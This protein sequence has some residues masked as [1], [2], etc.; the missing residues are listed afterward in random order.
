[1]LSKEGKPF[2]LIVTRSSERAE[3][4]KNEIRKLCEANLIVVYHPEF[5]SI[6]KQNWDLI[7]YDCAEDED[8]RMS[9]ML[10]LFS[11]NIPLVFVTDSKKFSE[12]FEVRVVRIKDLS[13]VLED[14]I[15][16]RKLKRKLEKKDELLRIAS[17]IAE[18]G[19]WEWNLETDR[20]YLSPECQ[21]ILG[22]ENPF[23]YEKN[24]LKFVISENHEEINRKKLE[25]ISEGKPF[26]LQLLFDSP[27]KGPTWISVFGKAEYDD[28]GNPK[29]VIGVV[30]DVSKQKEAE[31]KLLL[32]EARLKLI[33]DVIPIM[34]IHLDEKMKCDFANQTFCRF[35]NIELENA[36]GKDLSEIVGQERFSR[37]IPGVEKAFGGEISKFEISIDLEYRK[38]FLSVDFIPDRD[39]KGEVKGCFVFLRDNTDSRLAFENLKESEER[40]RSL[41]K[42]T[43]QIVW[44]SPVRKSLDK[45]KV[46]FLFDSISKVG[47][48]EERFHTDDYKKLIEDLRKN[49]QKGSSYEAEYRIFHPEDNSYHTYVLK[50]FPI[51][52]DGKIHEFIGTMTDVTERQKA[53]REIK[54]QAELLN[55]VNQAILTTDPRGKLIY[56][57]KFAEELFGW[58]NENLLGRYIFDLIVPEENKETATKITNRVIKGVPWSGEFEMKKRDGTRFIASFSLWSVQE[59]GRTKLV[60]GLVQDITEKKEAERRLKDS[61]EQLQQAQK[62]ESIGRLAGGIAHDFNNMLTAIKGY[63]ELAL[64]QLGEEKGLLRRSIEE[65]KRAA[66]RSSSLT[67]QLLAFSRRQIMKT[68]TLDVNQNI[69][70]NAFLIQRLVGEDITLSLSLNAEKSY[71]EADA[72]QLAQVLTNLAVNSRDAMP[73]GGIITIKTENVYLDE[74]FVSR[75]IEAKKG[76]YVK[77]SFKDTGCGMDEETLKH[78]FE[79]FFTTKPIGKG[80][81]LGLSTVYGIVKQLN[82]FIIC[83]SKL[84]QGTCFEI[85]LPVS[86]KTLEKTEKPEEESTSSLSTSGILL[87]EDEKMVRELTKEL[88]QSCGY[89]VF[90]A[91]NMREALSIFVMM[92]E[93]IDLLI[94]DIVMPEGNG[95]ELAIRLRRENPNLPVIFIS[96]YVDQI[97]NFRKF[98][99]ENTVFIPKPFSNDSLTKV[100]AEI[101]RKKS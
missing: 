93:K 35:H 71:I 101:I 76:E 18:I 52:K 38:Q 94:S 33:T 36:L 8:I 81:G 45:P 75:N 100:I 78:I 56:W 7:I 92:K 44:V 84:A 40:F 74:T 26:Q 48:I 98:E 25:A 69:K 53:E 67:Q 77:I 58:E 86:R 1:M 10:R 63:S 97:E 23:D 79:P 24:Y 30:Q 22:V 57:N 68:E 85:F 65:I 46:R 54:F 61:I 5:E 89:Q 16:E 87:V 11:L 80:T 21:Q 20:V 13:S 42:A 9:D 47:N 83:K 31:E 3:N 99:A 14:E 17:S 72:G 19:V 88:L 90:E 2:F 96:G 41:V 43:N 55:M 32:N 28:K 27:T 95:Y 15:E 39:E 50:A 70:E 37:L 6:P 91:K 82:G 62:L 49:A 12:P 59:S 29:K 60:I 66:E 34:I 64:R 51:F 4:I 73:K